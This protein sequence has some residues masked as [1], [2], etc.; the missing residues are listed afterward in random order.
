MINE[1]LS[2]SSINHNQ[3]KQ[4]SIAVAL[5]FFNIIIAQNTPTSL[6]ATIKTGDIPCDKDVTEK[7]VTLEQVEGDQKKII[8]AFPLTGCEFKVQKTL[9]SGNYS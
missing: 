6:E 7:I 3:M 9:A 2:A 4:I 8:G 5:L 1:V